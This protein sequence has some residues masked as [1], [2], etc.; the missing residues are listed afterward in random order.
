MKNHGFWSRYC[1]QFDLVLKIKNRDQTVNLNLKKKNRPN[2]LDRRVD[3]I[4][5]L[6]FDPI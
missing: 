2:Y 6:R 4:L 3:Q 5:K 1:L